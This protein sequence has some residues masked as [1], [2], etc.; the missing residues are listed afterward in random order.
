MCWTRLPNDVWVSRLRNFFIRVRGG[1]PLPPGVSFDLQRGE[2]VLTWGRVAGGG[3]A[4]ATDFALRVTATDTTPPGMHRW[5]EIVRAT[6]VDGY[7]TVDGVEGSQVR[8]RLTE[9]RGVPPAVR[10]HINATVVTSEHHDIEGHGLRVVARRDLST[11][12]LIWST[13]FDDPVDENDPHLADQANPLLGS[14]R[15]RLGG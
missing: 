10:E 7:L 15:R 8:Y 2:R 9:P 14:V 1:E 11:G 5:H 13:V 3:I 12:R 4:A 6:W